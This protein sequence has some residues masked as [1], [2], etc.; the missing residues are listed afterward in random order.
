MAKEFPRKEPAWALR[1]YLVLIGMAARHET[2]TYGELN[3]RIKRG[4][5]RF[6]AVPLGCVMLWCKQNDLPALTS[7][8]VE[9][10]IGLPKFGLKTVDPDKF[11]AEQQKVFRFDWFSII[12]PTLDD[13]TAIEK[14]PLRDLIRAN[15]RRKV[16]PT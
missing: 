8:I 11:P 5:A 3:Q 9:K 12:P 6:L 7:L 13:L 16:R 1:A 4:G 10:P 15:R 2:A 14:G